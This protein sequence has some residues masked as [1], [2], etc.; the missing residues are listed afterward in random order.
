MNGKRIIVVMPG[1]DRYSDDA[2]HPSSMRTLK[3]VFWSRRRKNEILLP[4]D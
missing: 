1:M 4:L 3:V 2:Q